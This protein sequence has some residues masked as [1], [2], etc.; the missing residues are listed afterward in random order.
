MHLRVI[1][2][3][4][5]PGRE[6]PHPVSIWGR[7]NWSEEEEKRSLLGRRQEE[8]APYR[9]SR[10]LLGLSVPLRGRAGFAADPANRRPG[11]ALRYLSRG[12]E[13]EHRWV[14]GP[15]AGEGVVQPGSWAEPELKTAGLRSRESGGAREWAGPRA[16][17]VARRCGPR[18]RGLGRRRAAERGVG[19][20][21]VGARP[22]SAMGG[23]LCRGAVPAESPLSAA[24]A[25]SPQ[26]L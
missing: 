22:E 7:G 11:A 17:G 18:G 3:P 1:R 9:G 16:V 23:A 24:A 12:K 8:R 15:G 20:A 4:S 26:R 13:S 25:A 21:R 6:V 10:A 14:A 2:S 5:L 19:G